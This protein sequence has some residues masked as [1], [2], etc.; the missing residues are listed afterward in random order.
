MFR[1]GYLTCLVN[2]D[3]PQTRTREFIDSRAAH[4]EFLA[5]CREVRENRVAAGWVGPVKA[6][7]LSPKHL[8]LRAFGANY[9]AHVSGMMY[10]RTSCQ[11]LVRLTPESSFKRRY[12]FPSRDVGVSCHKSLRELR[13]LL[14]VS[15][16]PVL[17]YLVAV[18]SPMCSF[19]LEPPFHCRP[20]RLTAG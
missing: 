16:Q 3:T 6:F 20:V 5:T 1:E 2:P 14:T 15:L 11:P 18:R 7:L 17:E 19:G 8:L 10:S 12:R 4:Q 13:C 9:C